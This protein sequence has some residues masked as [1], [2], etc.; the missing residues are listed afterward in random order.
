[1]DLV[2]NNFTELPDCGTSKR[3]NYDILSFCTSQILYD[4]P[5]KVLSF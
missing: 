1:M 4:N 3:P 5:V 2:R